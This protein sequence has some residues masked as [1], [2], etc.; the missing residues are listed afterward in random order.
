MPTAAGE[1]HR[2]KV[3]LL[4]EIKCHLFQSNVF[5]FRLLFYLCI[6]F[7]AQMLTLSPK[8]LGSIRNLELNKLSNDTISNV[9]IKFMELYTESLYLMY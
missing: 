9:G 1:N 3:T 6:F 4:Q 2:E 5:V 7:Y 8:I